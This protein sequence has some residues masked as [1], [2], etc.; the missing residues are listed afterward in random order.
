MK[1]NRKFLNLLDYILCVFFQV[2]WLVKWL[3]TPVSYT[4]PP[5]WTALDLS[6]GYIPMSIIKLL[7]DEYIYL[8]WS[9]AH[10]CCPRR[11]YYDVD[12]GYIRISAKMMVVHSDPRIPGLCPTLLSWAV[13]IFILMMFKFGTCVASPNCPSMCRCTEQGEAG[14]MVDCRNNLLNQLEQWPPHTSSIDLSYNNFVTLTNNSLYHSTDIRIIKIANSRVEYVESGVFQEYFSLEELYLNQNSI[15]SLPNQLF[16]GLSRLRI[17]DLSS[18]RIQELAPNIFAQNHNLLQLDL[19]S[20]LLRNIHGN[21]FKAQINLNRVDLSDNRFNVFLPDSFAYCSSL[22]NLNFSNNPI[23]CDCRISPLIKWISGDGTINWTRDTIPHCHSPQAMVGVIVTEVNLE[24]KGC[25]ATTAPIPLPKPAPVRTIITRSEQKKANQFKSKLGKIPYNPM[26]G[27]Y[28]ASALSGMLV[29][30]LVCVALDKAKRTF[31]KWRRKRRQM[32]QPKE[33]SI[34]G[35]VVDC[36]KLTLELHHSHNRL[37]PQLSNRSSTSGG[38][39]F[40]PQMSIKS[41]GS[42]KFPPIFTEVYPQ[43]IV[44]EVRDHSGLEKGISADKELNLPQC[45]T[46]L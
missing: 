9:L 6:S 13:W 38:S 29:L 15:A 3:T 5:I 42:D 16:H 25:V 1:T 17:L 41:N 27:W 18:N 19:S 10:N 11:I 20:N 32:R 34:D 2:Q 4:I 46:V 40:Q 8:L 37:Q 44:I 28:T 7:F 23:V 14:L 22:Q 36:S 39:K 35:F 43:D 33:G 31:Y 21:V 45:E 30:F 24:D 12:V 26:L